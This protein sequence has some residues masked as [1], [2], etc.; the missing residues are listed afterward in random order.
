MAI[1]S[2]KT[3]KRHSNPLSVW[4]RILSYPLVYLP[5]WY[6]SWKQG[7]AVAA[8]F[9]VNPVLFPEPE[10]DE[11]WATRGVLGEE[12]WTAERPRD[13]STALTG[14]S[15]AFF[16][17]GLWSAYKRRFWPTMFFGGT[18]FLL[19]LWYI[20]RMTFYYEQHREEARDKR[21]NSRSQ[22]Q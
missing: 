21:A 18:A 13:L 2:E 4:S 9:A 14:A 1:L 22:R 5:F 15:A 19:K 10:S 7:A 8:W 6:R 20:D 3:W 17:S 11:S 12:L 16:A